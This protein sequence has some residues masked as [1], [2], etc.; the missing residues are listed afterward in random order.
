MQ[1]LFSLFKERW[2]NLS[3]RGKGVVVLAGPAL[4]T[5]ISAVLF[6][7]TKEKADQAASLVMHTMLV[8][9]Q[10][11]EVISLLTDSETGMR[12]YLLTRDP[13]ILGAHDEAVAKLPGAIA[14]LEQLVRD[15][16]Q[17]L[18]RVRLSIAPL[19][20]KRLAIETMSYTAFQRQGLDSALQKIVT[21]GNSSMKKARVA[22]AEFLTAESS[23][24]DLRQEHEL[25]LK[26]RTG[27]AILLDVLI[28]PAL[29]LGAISLFVRGIVTR[30]QCI[31]EETEALQREEP[32][33][34]QPTSKDEI[35]QLSR[36]SREAGK[37]L[38]QRR[39][40]LKIAKEKAE[41]ANRAKSE[42]LANMSHEIRTPLNGI[43]GLTDLTLGTE[44]SSGQRDYLGMVKNSADLLL[45]LVNDILD[46]AKIEAGRLSLETTSFDLHKM[47]NRK[48]HLALRASEKGLTLTY[49]IGPD[50]PRFVRGDALRLHQTLVNLVVNAIK[51]TAVGGVQLRVA[52][53]AMPEAEIGLQF[54]V[55]DTGIGI[56]VEKQQL[57]FEAFTQADSS[58][59]R[60]F[61]GTGLGLAICAQLVRLMGGRIWLESEP[62]KGSTFHLTAGFGA[63]AEPPL[64]RPREIVAEEAA[65]LSLRIL[66]VDD[67]A[68]NRSVA[69]GILERQSHRVSFAENGREAVA[70]ARKERFDLILM[71]VQMPELDGFEATARIRAQEAGTSRR[72]PIIAMTAHAGK[73]DRARCL[74]AGMDEY[75]AKPISKAE[76]RVAMEKSLGE[77]PPTV[78]APPALP[79]S[80][81]NCNHLLEQFDGDHALFARVA[82]LFTEN[83]PG[84]LGILRRAIA[85]RDF[86][87]TVRVA[88]TLA[89]SL[90]NIGA[91]RA[92]TLAREIETHAHTQA[93]AESESCYSE[94]TDEIHSVLAG[95]GR[96]L[97]ASG[98]AV[99]RAQPGPGHPPTGSFR[100]A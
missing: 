16:P 44:L 91:S 50:V 47:I 84:L 48:S 56:P 11:E 31:V 96:A 75:V 20:Q 100:G 80:G 81:F 7:V 74:A 61:G 21:A 66:V 97:D 85:A 14:R 32:L 9:Q 4:A 69:G 30:V 28:G 72:T 12:G 40:E 62:G 52:T 90:A 54:S 24:L 23:L 58:T 8:Q 53:C 13:A 64:E 77:A 51:F 41:A 93:V 70:A 36:A 39:E 43:I 29:G 27:L 10:A 68:V 87:A 1:T 37:L 6:F 88:H 65:V 46:V 35:G 59:T 26:K 15:N 86:A 19:V 78:S 34:E 5:I 63:V 3:L 49:D 17:Q 82:G 95:L 73:D 79:K 71:D 57:I 83:T 18:K 25:R 89:G 98:A 99:A 2:Q 33:P 45:S 38:A 55:S 94:L 42:F 67:N 92:S 60:E 76:L 22:V